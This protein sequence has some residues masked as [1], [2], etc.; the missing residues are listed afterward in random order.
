MTVLCQS[1]CLLCLRCRVEHK[2]PVPPGASTSPNMPVIQDGHW[3][4]ML[5][6]A[7]KDFSSLLEVGVT[8]VVII[9]HLWLVEL[10]IGLDWQWEGLRQL[11]ISRAIEDVTRYAHSFDDTRSWALAY[12]ASMV[13]LLDD[14]A[15]VMRFRNDQQVREFGVRCQIVEPVLIVF[16]LSVQMEVLASAMKDSGLEVT[17]PLELGLARLLLAADGV[18]VVATELNSVFTDDVF[19]GHLSTADAQRALTTFTVPVLDPV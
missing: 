16:V 4:R 1:I 13:R 11:N 3:A 18:D 17:Q 2:T 14:V 10:K 19:K 8:L 15:A 12:K 9:P 5:V 7:L 6:F